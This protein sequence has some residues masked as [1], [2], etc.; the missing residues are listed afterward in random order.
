M[1]P[2]TKTCAA[3]ALLGAV[4]LGAAP[5]GAAT[6]PAAPPIPRTAAIDGSADLIPTPGSAATFPALL[7]FAGDAVLCALTSPSG[8]KI[9]PT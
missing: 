9:C 7:Q 4:S 5:A 8:L 2:A 3:M 1:I 6:A